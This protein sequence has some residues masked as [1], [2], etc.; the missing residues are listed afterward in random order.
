MSNVD[1]RNLRY[2]I[3]VVSFT[4]L[5]TAMFLDTHSGNREATQHFHKYNKARN[6]ALK[7]YNSRFGPLMISQVS[8][9]NFMRWVNNPWPWEMEG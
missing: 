3:D 6:Q 8:D 4:A 9:D 5:D 1:Q 2:Y 7:E